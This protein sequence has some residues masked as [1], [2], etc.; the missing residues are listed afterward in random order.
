MLKTSFCEV[1]SSD[2]L[3]DVLD[4]GLHPL[5]DDLIPTGSQLTCNEYPIEI[6][7]CGTC[8]T[9]HQKHQVE[10][11]VLFPSS[12]HYRSRFTADVLSGMSNLVESCQK[13]YGDL[14]G[15]KILDVGCNDGSLLNYFRDLGA[16]SYGIEPTDASTDASKLG[17]IVLNDYFT[18]EVAIKF[19]E[20]YGFP[21]LITFTNVFA[22]IENLDDV[23]HALKILM[24]PSTL[25]V[26]ENH[27]LGSVLKF[28]QFDTF[29]H[30][31]PRTYSY[32]SFK[33]IAK[34]L[35][36]ELLGAEFPSRYGGNIR[37]HIGQKSLGTF[38]QTKYLDLP[39]EE[40]FLMN[41]QALAGTV[42]EWRRS[43]KLEIEKLVRLYGPLKAKAFPGRAAIL[44]RLLGLTDSHVEAVYEKPGSM[45]IGNYLPGSRIEIRSDEELFMNID[46]RVPILNFAWHISAEI[47]RY[48]IDNGF[49]G[50]VVD[51][52]G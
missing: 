34:S 30:E 51:V 47:R 33:F 42:E 35:D 31:H 28:S 13:S 24:K 27:Y 2:G 48:L 45:K 36:R 26:I 5:C 41:F 23:I 12:Y 1:C 18:P 40:D 17:H 22:H 11:K 4:L 20:K 9:A 29:Y 10:K 39:N 38:S 16:I 7:F 14:T 44:V 32:E 50:P 46:N 3:T 21:D 49:S 52:M 25:L 6:A 43:K 8:K 15:K 19:K 37:V